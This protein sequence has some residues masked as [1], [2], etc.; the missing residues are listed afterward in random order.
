MQASDEGIGYSAEVVDIAQSLEQIDRDKSLAEQERRELTAIERALVKIATGAF[1][2]CEDCDE[3][4]PA[5]RLIVLPEARLCA[6]CQEFEERQQGRARGM[7][8][9]RAV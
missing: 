4:I 6:K 5:K 8:I 7:P 1:G 9:A 2:V 3:D